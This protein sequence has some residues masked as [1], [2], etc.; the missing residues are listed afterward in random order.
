[1]AL[2]PEERRE[3]NRAGAKRWYQKNRENLLARANKRYRENREDILADIR[4]ARLLSARTKV[5]GEWGSRRANRPQ[6]DCCEIC[7]KSDRRLVW[8]HC[9][10][11]GIFRGW[12]CDRCNMLLGCAEDDPNYL[13]KLIAYLERTK[14]VSSQLVLSGM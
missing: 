3:R 13:R 9:H 1:M 6:P 11:R 12:I 4:S 2:T 14:D 10:Q 7:G 5:P 8:D